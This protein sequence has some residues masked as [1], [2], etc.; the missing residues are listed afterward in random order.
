MPTSQQLLLSFCVT[1][2][3]SLA[4]ASTPC[5]TEGITNTPGWSWSKMKNSTFCEDT[6]L[7]EKGGPGLCNQKLYTVMHGLANKSCEERRGN[8]TWSAR[9]WQPSIC[10]AFVYPQQ[11][12]LWENSTMSDAST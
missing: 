11:Y 4:L 12:I 9:E 1:W 7:D 10:G 2:L 8:F 5:T 3:L 6:C